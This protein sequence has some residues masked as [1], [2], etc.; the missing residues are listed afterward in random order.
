MSTA[1]RRST[2]SPAVGHSGPGGQVFNALVLVAC[3][4]QLLVVL[5]MSIVNVALPSMRTS[6]HMDDAGLQWVVNAY[7]I[8]FAGVVL[9]GG[10]IADLIGRKAAFVGGLTLFAVASLL[11]GLAVNGGMLVGGRALQGLGAAALAPATLTLLTANTREGAERVRAVA[12]WSGTSAAGGAVGAVLGGILTEVI[13]WRWVLL[14]NVPL[15][16]ATLV[17]G[18][19]VLPAASTE[20]LARRRRPDVAGAAAITLCLAAI[21]FGIVE[22]T[23]HGWSSTVVLGALAVGGVLVAAFLL[24][25]ARLA[26]EPL[27]PLGLLRARALAAGNLV[28]LVSGGAFVAVWYFVTLYQ[29]EVLGRGP[30]AAGFGFLPHALSILVA[31]QISGRLLGSRSPRAVMVAGLAMSTVGFLWQAQAPADGGYLQNVL[32]P[33]VL[34]CFG[35]GLYFPRITQVAT[36][37]VPREAA[38]LASGVLNASRWIGGALGLAVLATIASSRTA[39][40]PVTGAGPG[41]VALTAGFDRAFL[42]SAGITAVGML[43]VALVPKPGAPQTPPAVPVGPPGDEL[44]AVVSMVKSVDSAV[45]SVGREEPVTT[46]PSAGGARRS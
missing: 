15:A 31:A 2:V 24:I 20:R 22:T 39:E 12:V 29:Q 35:A 18:L 14:V 44:V 36:S 19:V 6:L 1:V 41:P 17:A 32:V 27:V 9:L 38:G 34:I 25:E 11:G 30:L 33:G 16:L 5:D 46:R 13:S 23:E 37:G 45:G 43:L 3:A 7:T 4:G 40:F 28:A 10:R 21:V 42:L 26:S 8:A